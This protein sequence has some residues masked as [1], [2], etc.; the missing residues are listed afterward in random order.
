MADA[1]SGGS[2]VFD[3]LKNLAATL[4]AIVQT[5]IELLATEIE[6]ERVRLGSL[7]L[8]AVVALFCLGVGVV[9]ATMFIV[10]AFWE[11]HRLFVLGFLALLFLGAGAALWGVVLNKARARPSALLAT[12]L[13][14]LAKDREQLTR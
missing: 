9:L 13:A 2:G 11:T 6:E 7:L 8:F 5:R 14:E 4:V 12:S 3:S 1:T 10:V